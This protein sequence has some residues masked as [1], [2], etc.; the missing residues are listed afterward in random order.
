MKLLRKSK[1]LEGTW[2]ARVRKLSDAVLCVS[3]ETNVCAREAIGQKCDVT[4]WDSQLAL[5]E[6]GVSTY[7]AIDVV[8]CTSSTAV[9]TLS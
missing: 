1:K 4:N 7:G 5:F 8:V 2:F 3:V 6:L 9:D